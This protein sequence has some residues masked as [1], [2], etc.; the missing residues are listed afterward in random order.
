MYEM[1]SGGIPFKSDTPM[2]MLVAH[3]HAT[4]A[5]LQ[6]LRPDRKI[7]DA[8]ATVVMKCLEKKPEQRP[9]SAAVLIAE[10]ER[11]EKHRAVR[12]ATT[13]AA[14][15]P[16]SVDALVAPPDPPPAESIT[17]APAEPPPAQAR[18]WVGAL[19]LAVVGLMVWYFSSR[20]S[21]QNPSGPETTPFQRSPPI[22]SRSGEVS[23]SGRAA[24]ENP[25]DGLKYV[26]IPPGTFHM[27]CS[28]SDNECGNNEKPAHQ[29]TIAK[30]FWMGQT[31]V[32]VAAYR[33]LAGTMG[34]QMPTAPDFNA[35][36]SK[37]HMPIVGVTWNDANA[38]SGW[39]GGVGIRRARREHRGAKRAI[40]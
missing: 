30:G 23:A 15:P 10:L 19:G 14:S 7:P 24:M 13:R 39:A 21:A 26:R 4:P 25:K 2:G 22:A 5:P 9:A 38:F 8:I 18:P 34:A 3:M 32:T 28:P 11:A 16:P 12:F 20:P 6:S 29:V 40:R 37:Q 31:E 17:A 33:K 1:L 27:D 36:W 35:G